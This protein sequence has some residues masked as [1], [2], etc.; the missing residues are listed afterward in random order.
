[1]GRSDLKR[2]LTWTLLAGVMALAYGCALPPPT[3]VSFKSD[4]ETNFEKLRTFAWGPEEDSGDDTLLSDEPGLA[5]SIRSAAEAELKRKGFKPAGNAQ[6]DFILVYRVRRELRTAPVAYRQGTV[7]DPAV[8]PT[9]GQG[10]GPARLVRRTYQY[11]GGNLVM[12]VKDPASGQV[13]WRGQADGAAAEA[14]VR[15]ERVRN[16][17]VRLLEFFPPPPGIPS[18]F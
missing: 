1:M 15:E 17:V 8:D 10:P 3:Q 16:A 13:L 9:A 14:S 18:Y 2:S 4:R 7:V 11:Q 5:R 6:P 12:L